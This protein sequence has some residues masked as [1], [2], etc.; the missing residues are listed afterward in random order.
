MAVSG[1]RIAR[2]TQLVAFG[3]AI[4]NDEEIFDKP[5]EFKPERFLD[6]EGK[7]GG[8]EKFLF[9]GVG[10]RRFIIIN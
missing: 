4:N 2:D 3:Y 6:D 1:H 5:R 8:G 9:F 10:K 7:F